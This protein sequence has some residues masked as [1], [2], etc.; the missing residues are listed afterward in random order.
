MNRLGAFPEAAFGFSRS[1]IHTLKRCH[2]TRTRLAGVL[3]PPLFHDFHVS[4]DDCRQHQRSLEVENSKMNDVSIIQLELQQKFTITPKTALLL[5]KSGFRDYR[6]LSTATP[7][8]IVAHF[9]GN[10]GIPKTSASAYR[11]ACR[12]LVFLATQDDPAEQEKICADW[13]NKALAARGIWRDDFDDLTGTQIE[14]LVG[15]TGGDKLLRD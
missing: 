3:R 2:A 10:L 15:S 7:N 4:I 5:I 14:E 8:S 9:T 1:Y 11:R 13:T 12:R 6:D